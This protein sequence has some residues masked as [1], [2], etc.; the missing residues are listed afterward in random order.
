MLTATHKGVQ[1]MEKE[2]PSAL[3]SYANDKAARIWKDRLH[4][5]L[6]RR[7]K[8]DPDPEVRADLE[9]EGSL[10]LDQFAEG[11]HTGQWAEILERANGR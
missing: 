9:K 11:V 1:M 2:N 4:S 6:N 3:D 8:G 10:L 7:L 5:Y